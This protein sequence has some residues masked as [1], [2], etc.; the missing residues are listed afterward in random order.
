MGIDRGGMCD[1]GES[2]DSY[3]SR[4]KEVDKE[5][6]KRQKKERE[7]QKPVS[8]H[9]KQPGKYYAIYE[10]ENLSGSENIGINKDGA[11]QYADWASIAER[12]NRDE[13][14][15]SRLKARLR[16]ALEIINERLL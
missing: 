12:L 16:D 2:M 6:A 11:L 4:V 1:T 5:R 13:D 8:F 15:I 10:A 14:Q 9:M 3:L 7:K